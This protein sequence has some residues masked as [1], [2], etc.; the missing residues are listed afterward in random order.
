M[1]AAFEEYRSWKAW[2]RAPFGAFTAL[3][4]RAYEAELSAAGVALDPGLSILE[5]GF[6]AGTFAGWALSRGFAYVGIELDPAL[7]ASARLAGF[8]AFGAERPVAQVAASRRFDLIVA[9]DVLEHMPLDEI[10]RLMQALRGRLAEGGRLL[11]RFP[12]G[13][14]PFSGAIQHGDLTHRT[15]IGSGIVEQLA[16]KTGYSVAQIRAPRLPVFGVGLLRGLRRAALNLARLTTGR[17]INLIYHDNQNR[18]VD[19][20]M[21]IVLVR[22]GP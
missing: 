21:V 10:A 2:D 11:A 17:L 3:D 18:V 6:G 9:F 12:S 8:E 14:S 4:A 13:D 1:D 19:P 5:I 15:A 7:V 20:N 22:S 16:L